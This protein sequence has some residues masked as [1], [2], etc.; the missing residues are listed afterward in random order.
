MNSFAL[1]NEPQE[2]FGSSNGSGQQPENIL[3]A[4]ELV[5]RTSTKINV[6]GVVG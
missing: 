5:I 6:E 1:S 2:G 4:T 3:T